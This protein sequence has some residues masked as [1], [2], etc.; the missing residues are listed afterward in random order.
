MSITRKLI[1]P[2]RANV[3]VGLFLTVP[4]VA[5]VLIF[6][7]L[8]RMTT[9]WLPANA[10]PALREIWHGYLLRAITL[11][12]IV[13]FLYLVGLLTRNYFGRRLYQFGDKVLARI[14]VIRS[15]YLSVRQISE[16][17][18]TQRKTL[19]KEVVII[20]YPRK[21]LYSLAFVTAVVPPSIGQHVAGRNH[22]DSCISL[23][24]PTTPN[25]TSGI[26]VLV[27]KTEVIPLDIPVTD[28]LT[29][30]MSAGAVSPGEEGEHP[31]TL[32]DKLEGWLKHGDVTPKSILL[33]GDD[34][35]TPPEA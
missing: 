5:T 25:P 18:F 17:L 10:F 6:N 16:S 21:G 20:Q 26:L 31:P 12:A 34:D 28:A 27:P 30:V 9:N 7:F 23:F 11:L 33:T 8:L 3:L 15:I 22:P 2:M 32:L 14:P 24:V 29:F 35:D 13:L 1:A 4:V 19:F